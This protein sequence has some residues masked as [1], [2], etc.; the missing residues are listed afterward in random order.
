M[1]GWGD[2]NCQM[3]VSGPSVA[4]NNR[5]ASFETSASH[6]SAL[7]F[8]LHDPFERV[9]RDHRSGGRTMNKS[10]SARLDVQHSA[11]TTARLVTYTAHRNDVSWIFR[12][13]FELLPKLKD[14]VVDRARFHEAFIA[15][16]LIEY[17]VTIND[18]LGI[19]HEELKCSEFT[20][21]KGDRLT[22]EGGFHSGRSQHVL[23]QIRDIWKLSILL[24]RNDE[25]QF[26]LG[27]EVPSG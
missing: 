11:V 4:C 20:G 18:P 19:F 14:V 1:R 16:H 24:C 12:F 8:R 27:P 15:E 3:F 13:S 17:F 23:H 7:S 5:L 6:K 25:L 22:V 2:E 26:V 10:R 9:F 21:S